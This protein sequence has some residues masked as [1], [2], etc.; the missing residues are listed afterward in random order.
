M[1]I[2]EATELASADSIYHR[3]WG[4]EQLKSTLRIS[5]QNSEVRGGNLIGRS[6]TAYEDWGPCGFERAIFEGVQI[7]KKIARRPHP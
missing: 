1:G 6:P 4:M 2:D 3:V 7:V 5:P